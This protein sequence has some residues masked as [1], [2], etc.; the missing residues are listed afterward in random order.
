MAS[1]HLGL[2]DE[3]SEVEWNH[4]VGE[5]DKSRYCSFFSPIEDDPDHPYERLKV[6]GNCIHYIVMKER[7]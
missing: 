2:S 4:E 3:E 5:E 7:K 1:E 6:C